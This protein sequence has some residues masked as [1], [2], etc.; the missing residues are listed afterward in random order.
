MRWVFSLKGKSLYLGFYNI[1]LL[2]KLHISINANYVIHFMFAVPTYHA[3]FGCLVERNR[4]AAF[5]LAKV[6]NSH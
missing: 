4:Q 6:R 5:S 3:A 2:I 1:I